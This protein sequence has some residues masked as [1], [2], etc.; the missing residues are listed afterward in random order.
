[1]IHTALLRRKAAKYTQLGKKK[2]Q[3]LGPSRHTAP[4]K[5]RK[6]PRMVKEAMAGCGNNQQKTLS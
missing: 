5:W 1:M 3:S 6:L 4:G 2:I